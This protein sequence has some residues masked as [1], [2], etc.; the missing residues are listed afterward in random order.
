MTNKK[1]A[2]THEDLVG[3]IKS[4]G[5]DFVTG[6]DSMPAKDQASKDQTLEDLVKLSHKRHKSGQKPGLIKD[7]E[8]AVELDLIQLEKLW[9]YLGLPN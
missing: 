6:D 4:K 1:P 2:L 9:Q 8:S 5:W 7:V 3:R